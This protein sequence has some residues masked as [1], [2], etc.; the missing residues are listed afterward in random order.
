MRICLALWDVTERSAS[1]QQ[2]AGF[3][4]GIFVDLRA[5][6]LLPGQPTFFQT[7][8]GFYTGF[9]ARGGK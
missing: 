4:T 2:G 7:T 6:N 9:L 5:E 8:P 3:Y 1:S